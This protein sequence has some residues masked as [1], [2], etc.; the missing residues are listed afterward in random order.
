M[1]TIE[2]IIDLQGKGFTSEQLKVLH[3]MDITI[4]SPT[5]EPEKKDEPEPE[6]K[7]ESTPEPEKKQEP[8]PDVIGGLKNE[9]TTLTDTIKA[10][11]EANVQNAKAD[12]PKT[13][14]VED[15]IKSFMV[16]S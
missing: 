11:Q 8:E 9:I 6:K 15:I 5:P 10:M 13:E 16:A 3:E 12:P 1:L 4:S 7:Q 2:Q 14:S